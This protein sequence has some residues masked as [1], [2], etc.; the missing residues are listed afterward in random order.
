M[1]IFNFL[2]NK[3][4]FVDNTDWLEKGASGIFKEWGGS[5]QKVITKNSSHLKNC[6]IHHMSNKY[7][8]L[9]EPIWQDKPGPY[10]LTQLLT[11]FYS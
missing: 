7:C 5:I 2:I 10:T 9:Q 11:K 6:L 1:N 4:N 8:L 3:F